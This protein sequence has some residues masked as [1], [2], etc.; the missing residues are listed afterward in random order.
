MPDMGE[1]KAKVT[2][3]YD[4]SGIQQAKEDIASL[5]D[6]AGTFG[7]AA[8][9]IGDTVSG[10]GDTF[11]EST[12]GVTSFA[13]VVGSLDS[14]LQSSVAGIGTFNDA[15]VGTQ[16]IVDDASTS[17]SGLS[18][19]LT[20]TTKRLTE[21]TKQ[22]VDSSSNMSAF[23]NALSDPE[24]F[25]MIQGYLDETGQTWQDFSESVSSN[26][27]EV[28]DAFVGLDKNIQP[29][30]DSFSEMFNSGR[31]SSFSDNVV[32]K[33]GGADSSINALGGVGALAYGPEAPPMP[34]LMG[35]LSNGIGGFFSS[36]MEGLN[37]IA[38]P[39]MAIQMIGAAV[40][41]VSSSI[42]N[43]AAVAEGPAAHSMGSFTGTID[44]LGQK[45]Q[46]SGANF[47]EGFGKGLLPI[48]QAVN[49][50][51]PN[52]D[53]WG[54]VG[55][56]IGGS[57]SLIGSVGEYLGGAVG[58]AFSIGTG[59]GSD[60]GALGLMQGGVMGMANLWAQIGGQPLPFQGP[61][62][63]T[64]S[65]Q[66]QLQ[67]QLANA[68][69]QM[70]AQANDPVYL[71]AQTELGSAQAKATKAQQEYDV[72]HYTGTTGPSDPMNAI[73][74]QETLQSR[75]QTYGNGT[76]LDPNKAYF[77]QLLESA[78]IIGGGCF[79]AGT[80]V[81][82]SDGSYHSI[83]ILKIGDEVLAHDGTEQVSATI[84]AH[85][86]PPPKPVHT[87]ILEYGHELILTD[88]HPI[89]TTQ[90][91]KSLD[92]RKTKIENPDLVVTTLQVGDIV[93]MRHGTARL[94]GILQKSTALVQI[95]NITVDG[96]HTFYAEDVLVH[97][98]AEVSG[99][100]QAPVFHVKPTWVAEDLEHTFQGVAS[101]VGQ[102]LEHTFQGVAGWIGQGLEHTFQGVAGWIGQE[103]EHTF[104]GVA[105][106][107]GQGL[108]HTFQGV[109]NWIGQELEHTFEGITT[110]IGEN[111]EH[112]F[113]GITSWI[114]KGLENTFTG[115]AS[116]VGENLEHTFTGIASWVLG[117]SGVP[118][119][120]S[121]VENFDGGLAVVG[122]NGPELLNLP[123]GSSVYPMSGGGFGAPSFNPIPI[124]GGGGSMPQSINI[125]V[126]L[127][128]HEIV[129]SMGIPFAQNIRLI[130]GNRSG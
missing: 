106:W 130:S 68:T 8:G 97:N 3:E 41:T 55:G 112:T 22:L 31:A 49:D 30:K 66:V 87:L 101:W 115:I 58:E 118:G 25:Y 75:G 57:L 78:P 107:L 59:H 80:R 124:S 99:T 114:G 77:Q 40:G 117:G 6:L 18:A 29:F 56:A 48:L 36:A 23:Q 74:Q 26:G 109:A 111:L 44:V 121:G 7:D 95:Y 104:Q 69:A 20:E 127:G 79:P 24:P 33:L 50:Q 4:G 85:I 89:A 63:S 83:E 32:G 88:S 91:W 12:R 100:D 65:Q 43:M 42:Y 93:C 125:S 120:A 81:L 52:S 73:L 108:E 82:M 84:L 70:Q 28:R 9:S 1:I 98:K 37:A 113:T 16:G 103:L 86:V 51:T 71:A 14:P 128:E 5:G 72:S 116:W 21:T 119:F 60:A 45:A 67:K 76:Q 27:G 19:P 54:K 96:A 46:Q 90:G 47:S 62:P 10:L 38:M 13:D 123:S 15:F 35:D 39:L 110:W 61:G 122:E 102:A 11:A 17:I 126:H 129:S 94:L 105:D 64:D 2:V 53:V 34:S 92:P